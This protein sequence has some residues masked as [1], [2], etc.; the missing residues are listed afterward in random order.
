L[1]AR[2]WIRVEIRAFHMEDYDA[3]LRL[4][5][6]AGLPS[7]PL[8]RDSRESLSNEFS[9]GV[10]SLLVAEEEGMVVGAVL[11]T[12]DGRKGWINRLVVA[13]A[14]RGHG[15]GRRLVAEVE[16]R[17]DA[18]GLHIVACLIE[19][20]NVGSMRFFETLGY[21]ASPDIVYFSKRRS[22]DS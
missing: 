15:L 13:P 19:A 20:P 1:Q 5:E 14:Y 17:F 6:E 7:R 9:F 8:G 3:V 22:A 4:W 12:H 21:L 11:G 10:G 2:D 16:A 18:V